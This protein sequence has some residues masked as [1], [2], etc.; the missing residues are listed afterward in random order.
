VKLSHYERTR[1]A[2]AYPSLPTLQPSWKH[3]KV[4]RRNAVVAA[5]YNL[6]ESAWKDD[7][8]L[9]RT[10]DR[11]ANSYTAFDT[12]LWVHDAIGLRAR[13]PLTFEMLH[14]TTVTGYGTSVMF[15]MAR[16][17]FPCICQGRKSTF[18][19][20]SP[21]C[22]RLPE[23]PPLGSLRSDEGQRQWSQVRDEVRRDVARFLEK[24]EE[25]V[26]E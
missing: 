20:S 23:P 13:P 26:A 4:Y 5:R 15:R 17:R 1:R 3:T 2:R 21:I 10:D 14:P 24:R 16:H 6:I 8:G 22:R 9:V 12:Y 18:R 11:L 7:H 19:P 25:S